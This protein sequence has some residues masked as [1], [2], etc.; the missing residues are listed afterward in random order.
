M[1]D[2]TIV[3]FFVCLF[4]FF[5]LVFFLEKCEKLEFWTK[6]VVKA[7]KIVVPRSVEA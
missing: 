3:V 4:L 5:G 7:W 1:K 6:K 2:L